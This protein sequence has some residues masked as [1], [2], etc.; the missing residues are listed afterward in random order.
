MREMQLAQGKVF[1]GG[2]HGGYPYD[3]AGTQPCLRVYEV[4]HPHRESFAAIFA[5]LICLGR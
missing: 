1:K 5:H 2:Q 4:A 3:H